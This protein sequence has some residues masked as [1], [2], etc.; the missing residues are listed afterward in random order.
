MMDIPTLAAF[1][2]G[3]GLPAGAATADAVLAGLFAPDDMAARHQ[4]IGL[5]DALPLMARAHEARKMLRQDATQRAAYRTA[6]REVTAA[7]EAGVRAQFA[8]CLDAPIGFRERLTAFWADH[9]TT[10]A[11]SAAERPLPGTLVHDALRPHVTGRFAD[12]LIAATLHPAML[13]FL[14]QSASVGPLSP[15]GKRRNRGVNE[16]L[17]R[18]VME[19][20]SLGVT[21]D[22]G[23]ADV[24][25]MALLLTGLDSNLR[26]GFVFHPDRAEPGAEVV[27]GTSYG[28]DG[29]DPI[30]AALTDL[31]RHPATAAHI[32]G[33][34]AVHFVSDAPDPDLV[35]AMTATYLETDGDLLAVYG[36]MLNHP[37]AWVPELMKARQ[38]VEFVLAALRSLGMTGDDLQRMG[39]GP[40]S[41]M[42]L[43]PMGRMGQDWQQP[44]GPDG[45][46]EEAE[47]W[48]TPQGLS[49]RITWAMEVPGRLV[50]PMPDPVAFARRALGSAADERVLWA[51]ARAE[52]TR[53]GVGLVL[54][55]PA[56]NRR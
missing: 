32:A 27:L 37:S 17:A 12:M 15:V 19:L 41:R 48:I 44:V 9:F 56:F 43:K 14:D 51:V 4:T 7:A 39:S 36:S 42:I 30:K 54:A 5:G 13:V 11:R 40:F 18:E 22:Y 1:R 33:K 34:L 2:F 10:K 53:E 29:L 49:A 28:G 31:A 38:P 8:R 50:R 25:Q 24:R 23:Q 46:A 16:N 55:A 45:W 26:D 52:S 6:I 35:R 21:A 47:A 3:Y 20:H